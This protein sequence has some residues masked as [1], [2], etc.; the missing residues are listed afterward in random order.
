[1]FWTVS[2]RAVYLILHCPS[3]DLNTWFSSGDE[4]GGECLNTL[5]KGFLFAKWGLWVISTLRLGCYSKVS[6]YVISRGSISP[7]NIFLTQTCKVMPF[8]FFKQCSRSQQTFGGFPNHMSYTMTTFKCI[9]PKP[10]LKSSHRGVPQVCIYTNTDCVFPRLRGGWHWMMRTNSP[11]LNWPR[12]PGGEMAPPWL[13]SSPIKVQE[14][15]CF[16]TDFKYLCK[17]L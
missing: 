17:D 15:N 6:F 8:H 13:S 5:R 7:L 4:E 9:I 16:I 12:P 2:D 14:A 11:P 1:M 3:Y 10:D